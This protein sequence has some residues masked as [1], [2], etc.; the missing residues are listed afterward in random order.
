MSWS[1]DFAPVL[2][3]PLFWGAVVVALLLVGYLLLRRARGAFLRALALAAVIAALAN[4]TLR[5]EQR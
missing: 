4:P 5:E 3:A 2:P 1:I